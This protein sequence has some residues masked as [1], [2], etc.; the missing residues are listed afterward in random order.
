MKLI[1]SHL[2]NI[3][4]RN[5]R[6]R[7]NSTKIKIKILNLLN[8]FHHWLS[9]III[10]DCGVAC[11]ICLIWISYRCLYVSRAVR[12]CLLALT[13]SISTRKRR[14]FVCTP[15]SWTWMFNFKRFPFFFIVALLEFPY[16]S[17][18][19][20][21]FCVLI[22]AT[23]AWRFQVSICLPLGP[24]PNGKLSR[25]NHKYLT[26]TLSPCRLYNTVFYDYEATS[27]NTT[28]GRENESSVPQSRFLANEK[29]RRVKYCKRFFS[30][31]G[32][33]RRR[34]NYH[35]LSAFIDNN[36]S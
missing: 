22:R 23:I 12:C 27:N 20:R 36:W 15:R 10:C 4:A 34:M 18:W 7:E 19:L 11:Y 9:F 32:K 26:F 24:S 14:A 3:T 16:K 21:S 5:K 31:P 33:K 30:F 17:P 25:F 2:K 35:E 8:S 13:S 28:S 6:K 29:R 1:R